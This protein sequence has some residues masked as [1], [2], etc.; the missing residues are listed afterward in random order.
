MPRTSRNGVWNCESGDRIEG[1]DG[2]QDVSSL[3][4]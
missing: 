3:A 1:R 4:T 2:I